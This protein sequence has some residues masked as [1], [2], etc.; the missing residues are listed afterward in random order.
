MPNYY[1]LVATPFDTMNAAHMHDK[2]AASLRTRDGTA[3]VSTKN[4]VKRNITPTTNEDERKSMWG[5]LLNIPKFHADPTRW[6]KE[7]EKHL[8][9]LSASDDVFPTMGRFYNKDL[10]TP[11]EISDSLE[12]I[13]AELL[14][15][16]ELIVDF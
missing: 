4:K 10:W 13:K 5:T 14:E 2:N 1:P 9:T 15:G 12:R 11:K 6:N 7:W 16:Q 3:D 8:R